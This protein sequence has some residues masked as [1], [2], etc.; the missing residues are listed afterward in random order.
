MLMLAI[1]QDNN[2]VGDRWQMRESPDQYGRLG[3]Y[4]GAIIVAASSILDVGRGQGSVLDIF[5]IN[6]WR[7]LE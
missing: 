2:N 7:L 6:Y 3:I 1:L 4:E 5:C